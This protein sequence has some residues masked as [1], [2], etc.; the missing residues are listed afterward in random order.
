LVQPKV[1]SWATQIFASGLVAAIVMLFAVFG[2]STD[3][4]NTSIKN[5]SV[6]EQCHYNNYGYKTCPTQRAQ[7]K[8][9]VKGVKQM[10]DK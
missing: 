2:I 8:W 4:E 5:N 1:L 6:C 7:M 10:V 9:E 3:N